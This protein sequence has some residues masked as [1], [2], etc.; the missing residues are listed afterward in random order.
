MTSPERSARDAL[1]QAAQEVARGMAD[2]IEVLCPL[3]GRREQIEARTAM[4][5]IAAR[6]LLNSVEQL[7]DIVPVAPVRPTSRRRCRAG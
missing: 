7:Q 1:L 4:E 2:A 3:P 5:R 6:A